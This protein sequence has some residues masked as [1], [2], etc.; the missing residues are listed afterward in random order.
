MKDY[1]KADMQLHVLCQVLGKANRT[2]LPEKKDE[3]HTNLY[4]DPW[5]NRILGRWIP[6]KSGRLIFTLDLDSLKFEVL[7]A[8]RD[9]VLSLPSLGKT[10]EQIETDLEALLPEIKLDPGGFR[11]PMKHELPLYPFS[12]KPLETI[13]KK[14]LDQWK[15][16]RRLANR[17]CHDFLAY[18][19]AE[20]EVRIWPEHFDTGI[21]FDYAGRIGI[22]FGLAMEDSMV[23]EPYFYMAGYTK[24]DSLTY[25]KLPESPHWKW[26]LGEHWKGAVLPLSMI[27]KSSYQQREAILSEYFMQN[28]DWYAKN[29]QGLKQTFPCT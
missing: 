24:K 11:A 28:F 7:T 5:G 2:Y 1:N 17:S 25:D 3:S 9:K 15:N 8:S 4:F 10:M 12:K 19:Q 27:K 16:F 29:T 21:Y 22:G 14:G 13:E 26:E 20:S 6:G 18:A 23:G